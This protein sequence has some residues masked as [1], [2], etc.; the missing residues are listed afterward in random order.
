VPPVGDPVTRFFS[1]VEVEPESECWNWTG[2][3]GW[4]GYGRF[5]SEKQKNVFAHR[6]SYNRWNDAVPEGMQ[7]DH[8]CRNRRCANPFHLEAVTPRE[9]LM[10]GDTTAA[11]NAAKT[12]CKNGHPLERPNLYICPRGRRECRKCRAAATA[13]SKRNKKIGESLGNR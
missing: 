5:W 12:E 9:N 10:R 11:K 2:H 8:L 7:L 3:L 4:Q 1:F 6:W 13:R